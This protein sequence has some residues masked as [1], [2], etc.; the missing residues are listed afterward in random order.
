ML[1]YS[2]ANSQKLKLQRH[3]INKLLDEVLFDLDYDIKAKKAVIITENLPQQIMIDPIKVKQVFQN[4]ISNALKFVPK[5]I[6]PHIKINYTEHDDAH[7]ITFNDNGI[8]IENKYKELIFE[9]FNSLNSK[10]L[11][12]GTGIGLSICKKI[13]EHHGGRIWVDSSLGKGASFHISM[14]KARIN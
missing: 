4:L 5:D 9:P 6:A 14:P 3:D 8:G 11:Y 10:S 13:I 12:D 7:L 2:K 1:E